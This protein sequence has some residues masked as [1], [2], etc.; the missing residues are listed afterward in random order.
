MIPGALCGTSGR[1]TEEQ[2]VSSPCEN[3]GSVVRRP[4]VRRDRH[5]NLQRGLTVQEEKCA[6]GHLAVREWR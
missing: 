3:G 6:S 5:H 2:P 4:E 1:A